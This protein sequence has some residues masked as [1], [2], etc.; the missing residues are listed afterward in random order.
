MDSKKTKEDINDFAY[1]YLVDLM[2]STDHV[3]DDDLSAKIE[4]IKNLKGSLDPFILDK[5]KYGIK[6]PNFGGPVAQEHK[7]EAFVLNLFNSFVLNY[8]YTNNK[9]DISRI[10]SLMDYM[11]K[12]LKENKERFK[13]EHYEGL[14]ENIEEKNE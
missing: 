13:K 10:L 6:G 1:N 2:W 7:R 9:D 5:V 8:Y 14:E 11:I 12:I 3:F 4:F